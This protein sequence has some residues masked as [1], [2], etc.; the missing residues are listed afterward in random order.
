MD[1][2]LAA[3]ALAVAVSV[4]SDEQPKPTNSA[5]VTKTDKIKLFMMNEF[6]RFSLINE[7]KMFLSFMMRQSLPNLP[8]WLMTFVNELSDKCH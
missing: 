8:D 5:I 6:E 7:K 1:F 3:P 4:W 2:G